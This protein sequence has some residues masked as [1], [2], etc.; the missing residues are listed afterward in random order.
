MLKACYFGKQF[1]FFM[2]NRKELNS[3]IAVKG[4]QSLIG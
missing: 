2:D 4:W 1:D 3:N